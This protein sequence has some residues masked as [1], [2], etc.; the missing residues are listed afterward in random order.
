MKKAEEKQ[1]ISLLAF[2]TKVLRKNVM[3]ESTS[4]ILFLSNASSLCVIKFPPCC[5]NV[6]PEMI[7][8]VIVRRIGGGVSASIIFCLHVQLSK[9][10][11][12]II[13]ILSWANTSSDVTYQMGC[14][15]DSP[16][17][18]VVLRLLFSLPLPVLCLSLWQRVSW[19]LI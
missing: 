10:N 2:S 15:L 17:I 11:I 1:Y 4:H 3:R 6:G 9:A 5:T 13:P 14:D 19:P 7:V 16:P 12:V 8:P 18:L